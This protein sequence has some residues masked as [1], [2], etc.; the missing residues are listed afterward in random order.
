MENQATF[1]DYVIGLTVIVAVIGGIL[2]LMVEA[3]RKSNDPLRLAFYLLASI[4][5]VILFI[6]GYRSGCSVVG[7]P[8][9]LIALWGSYLITAVGKA[10]GGL[11]DG[12]NIPPKP[13]PLYSIAEGKRNAGQYLEAITAIQ[14]ELAKFP[15][16][17]KGQMLLGDIQAENLRDIGAAQETIQALAAQPG[18]DSKNISFALNRL[19]D[20]HLK[21]DK[22][23]KAAKEAIERIIEL[24]PGTEAAYQATQR[25]AHMDQLVGGGGEARR[26]VVKEQTRYIALEDGFDGL[27]PAP[28]DFEATAAKLVKRLETQPDDNEARELL[29]ILYARHFSRMDLACELIEQMLAQPGAPTSHRVHWLNLLAD[30]QITVATDAVAARKA[31]QRIIDTCPGTVDAEQATQRMLFIDR[32]IKNQKEGIPLRLGEYEQYIGLK[33]PQYPKADKDKYGV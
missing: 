14:A 10:A 22:D 1:L 31:L 21:I 2:W 11:Y 8:V 7:L 28:E 19:A 32:D 6:R 3:V 29:A 26:F 33:N 27:K 24:F 9:L 5:I 16:D 17:F 15:N 4:I 25:L 30:L 13:E 20:W 18:H 23:V 12:S